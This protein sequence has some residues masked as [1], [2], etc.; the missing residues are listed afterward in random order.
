[1]IGDVNIFGLITYFVIVSNVNGG[2]IDATHV[3]IGNRYIKF[4]KGIDLLGPLFCRECESHIF[5]VIC[6]SYYRLYFL[7]MLIDHQLLS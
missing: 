3:S 5:E 6:R 1:M 7:G 4:F 2:L